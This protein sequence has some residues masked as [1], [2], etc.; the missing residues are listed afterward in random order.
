MKPRYLVAL[1][2]LALAMFFGVLERESVLVQDAVRKDP[3]VFHWPLPCAA[4]VSQRGAGEKWTTTQCYI[5]T[6]KR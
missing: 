1:L 3:V 5:P 4:T 2:V 6:S